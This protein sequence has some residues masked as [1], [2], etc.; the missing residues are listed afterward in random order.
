MVKIKESYRYQLPFNLTSLDR[1][2]VIPL[3]FLGAR[4]DRGY[5]MQQECTP[6]SSRAR[7]VYQYYQRLL[8]VINSSLLTFIEVTLGLK[9]RSHIKQR[10]PF[11][12]TEAKAQGEAGQQL[13]RMAALLYCGDNQAVWRV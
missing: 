12:R 7:A 2:L 5:R 10:K 3:L 4:G 9:T 8:A 11:V 6:D 13:A 1:W